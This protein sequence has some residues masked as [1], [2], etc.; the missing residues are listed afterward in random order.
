MENILKDD[1]R[2]LLGR[3]EKDETFRK[4]VTRWLRSEYDMPDYKVDELFLMLQEICVNEDNK[5]FIIENIGSEFEEPLIT[6][7]S[8]YINQCG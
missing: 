3:L 2:N 7:L 8:V 4:L 6:L 5:D 1:L